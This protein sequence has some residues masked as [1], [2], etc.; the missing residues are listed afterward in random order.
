M[1]LFE[2]RIIDE[3]TGEVFTRVFSYSNEGLEE[4]MGKLKWLDKAIEAEI[5]NEEENEME[6]VKRAGGNE[7]V[8]S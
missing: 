6:E 3:E 5:K 1:Y 8:V 7:A 2:A 4:E